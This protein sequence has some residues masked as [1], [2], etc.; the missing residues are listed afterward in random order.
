[1]HQ[2]LFISVAI[3]IILYKT[4]ILQSLDDLNIPL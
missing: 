3:Y 1:M 2:A 4:L